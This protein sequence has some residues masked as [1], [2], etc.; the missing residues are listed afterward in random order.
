MQENPTLRLYVKFAVAGAILLVAIFGISA[1]LRHFNSFQKLTV[2]YK[3]DVSSVELYQGVNQNG[4]FR[5]T[6]QKLQTVASGETYKLKKGLYILRPSGEKIDTSDVAVTLDTIPVEK[7][8]SPNFSTEYL[9]TLL[10][11]EEASIQAAILLS[12]PSLSVLYKINPGTLYK[13]GEWYGTTLSYKGPDSLSRDT[14]R[15]VAHKTGGSWTVATNPPQISLSAKNHP[16][17]PRDVLVAVNAI[18]IGVPEIVKN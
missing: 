7:T 10:G 2:S 9:K 18:D 8:I 17:V 11:D 14:L 4:N 1:V 12:N 15:L 3:S 16:S 6:G 5:A 13:H